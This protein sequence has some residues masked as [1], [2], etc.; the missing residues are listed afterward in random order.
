MNKTLKWILIVLA[1]I[2]GLGVLSL[3]LWLM[4]A[5]NGGQLPA[6]DSTVLR[7][8]LREGMRD[9]MRYPHMPFT[10]RMFP[11]FGMFGFARMLLPLGVIALAVY[12]VIAL[13]RRKPAQTANPASAAVVTPAPA[14]AAAEPAEIGKCATCG[15]ERISEGEYCPFCGARQ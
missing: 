13:V 15:R 14:A 6:V 12:G 9:G 11:F 2:I 10:G 1:V 3:P 4:L 5:H 7:E 8:D